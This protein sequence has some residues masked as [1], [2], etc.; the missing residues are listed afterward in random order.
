MILH[1]LGLGLSSFE[2]RLFCKSLGAYPSMWSKEFGEVY[3]HLRAQ[4]KSNADGGGGRRGPCVYLLQQKQLP[5]SILETNKFRT[6]VWG[7]QFL[8][9]LQNYCSYLWSFIKVMLNF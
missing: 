9:Q 5:C 2:E 7:L 4:N 1:L 3:L 6:Q 8:K